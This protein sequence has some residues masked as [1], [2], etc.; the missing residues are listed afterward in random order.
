MNGLCR[1]CGEF[2]HFD[3]PCVRLNKG[4][5]NLEDEFEHK[6]YLYFHEECVVE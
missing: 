5:I 3:E 2:I 4:F 6:E 1:H